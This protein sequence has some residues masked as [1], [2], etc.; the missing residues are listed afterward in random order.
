M[1]CLLLAIALHCRFNKI[2]CVIAGGA[3]AK[4]DP[5]RIGV[6]DLRDTTQD[7]LLARLRSKLREKASALAIKKSL[8]YA[9]Y[10]LMSHQS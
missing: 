4:I 2:K 5:T 10:I 3:G 1:I 7:P 9:V 8:G 6:A